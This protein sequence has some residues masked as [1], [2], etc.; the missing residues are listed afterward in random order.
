LI[1]LGK[2]ANCSLRTEN[3]ATLIVSGY[4]PRD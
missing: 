4:K 3:E 1:G 2:P